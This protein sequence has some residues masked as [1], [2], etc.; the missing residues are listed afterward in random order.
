MDRPDDQSKPSEQPRPTQQQEGNWQYKPVDNAADSGKPMYAGP[1][2]EAPLPAP[3]SG[4]EVE[5]TASEFVAHEKSPAWYAL[6]ILAALG[7]GGVIYIWTKDVFSSLMVL[8]VGVIFAVAAGRKPR[9]LTYRLDD[10]GV[11]AGKHFRPY[12]DFKSFAYQEEGPFASVLFIP[13]TRFGLPFSI[14]MA[15]ED[16]QRVMEALSRHLPL[17]RGQPDGIERLMRRVRF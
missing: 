11:S 16:E 2:N 6:L 9:V 10:H 5:W 13:M 12:S 3:D 8:V 15:P 14:Y 17:E 7:I 1:N 4:V